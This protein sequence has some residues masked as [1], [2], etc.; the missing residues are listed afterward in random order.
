MFNDS[1]N[2]CRSSIGENKGKDF[3]DHARRLGRLFGQG[4]DSKDVALQALDIE[5]RVVKQKIKEQANEEEDK[6]YNSK[7]LVLLISFT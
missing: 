1:L 2:E 7:L 6:R 5:K 4:T 3:D